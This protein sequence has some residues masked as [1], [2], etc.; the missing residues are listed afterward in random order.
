M[1]GA[2]SVPPR[3]ASIV[4]P[5]SKARGE[6]RSKMHYLTAPPMLE[7]KVSSQPPSINVS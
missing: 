7:L 4:G 2:H 5:S 3:E 6:T 1:Q